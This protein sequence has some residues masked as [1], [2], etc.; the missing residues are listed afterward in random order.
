MVLPGEAMPIICRWDATPPS[1]RRRNA[2]KGSSMFIYYE[3]FD[4]DFAT[5]PA[6][7]MM[8]SMIR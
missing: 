3:N 8:I 4:V 2:A 7:F 6:R 5:T 1:W